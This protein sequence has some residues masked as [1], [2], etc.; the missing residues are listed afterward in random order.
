MGMSLFKHVKI[1]GI[2]GVVPEKTINIDDEICYYNYDQKKLARNKKILG[3]GTR[4]NVVDGETTCDLCEAAANRLIEEMGIERSTIDALVL[5]TTTPDYIAPATSFILHGKLNLDEHCFCM[6]MN[7]GCT[8]LIHA[9]FNVFSMIECGAI[10]KALI[11]CGDIPSR[12]NDIRN[13]ITSMLLADSGSAVLVEYIK[14]ENNS[15]FLTGSRGKNWDSLIVPAGGARFPIRKDIVDYE[16]TDNNGNYWHLWDD[17]MKGLDVFNFTM[18]VG[19]KS[20]VDLLKYSKMTTDDIDI[21]A[22]HQGNKQ[23]VDTIRKHANLPEK[24]VPTIAF[25]KYANLSCSSCLSVLFE[26]L[27][28]EMERVFLCTYGVGLSWGS[29]ILNVKNVYNG[30]MSIFKNKKH[31]PSRKELIDHWTKHFMDN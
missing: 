18:E 27:T 8:S 28:S 2:A 3:L 9:L 21:F 1:S 15:Y 13:R 25:E 19:P 26:S 20:I 24:K 16:V 4:H 14:N 31:I 11:L 6:D 22:L 5:A 29:C 23:I 17:I 30:K 12:R 7:G 10:K